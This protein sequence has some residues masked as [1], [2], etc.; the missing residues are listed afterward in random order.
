MSHKSYKTSRKEPFTFDIDGEPATPF[1]SRGGLGSLVL[2][3][4]ELGKLADVDVESPEGMSAIGQVFE[5][6]LGPDEYRRF[7]EFVATHDV[8]PEVL[9]A[10]LQDM[11]VAVMGHPL[12]QPEASSPGPTT[13]PRTYKVISPSDGSEPGSVTE[14]PLTPEKEAELLAAMEQNLLETPGSN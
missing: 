3:L 7:R 8:D 14:V 2:E 10:I 9:L 12:A 13:T 1:R 6:L 5:M 4:G 11:F